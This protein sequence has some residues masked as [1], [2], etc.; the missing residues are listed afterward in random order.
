MVE[1]FK[2]GGSEMGVI[3]GIKK[4]LASFWNHKRTQSLSVAKKE[5]LKVEIYICQSN[6]FS[7]SFNLAF[8]KKTLIYI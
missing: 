7:G 1:L 4:L 5:S 6:W 2:K 3:I 8:T